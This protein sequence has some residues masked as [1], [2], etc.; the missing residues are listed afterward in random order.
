MLIAIISRHS[1]IVCKCLLPRLVNTG[2]KFYFT[3]S[4]RVGCSIQKPIKTENRSLLYAIITRNGSTECG[5]KLGLINS[6]TQE[7]V[8]TMDSVRIELKE[9]HRLVVF[10]VG[11]TVIIVESA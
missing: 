11:R 10:V 6:Q 3:R 5:H 7:V 1:A 4:V 9:V 8:L 2:H